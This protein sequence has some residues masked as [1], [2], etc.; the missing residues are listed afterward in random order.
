MSTEW[1]EGTVFQVRAESNND[2]SLR[3]CCY[4]ELCAARLV[5]TNPKRLTKLTQATTTQSQ[6]EQSTAGAAA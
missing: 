3:G 5:R 2:G 4:Q 6:T 1:F